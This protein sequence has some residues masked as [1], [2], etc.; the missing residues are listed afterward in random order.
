MEGSSRER[1]QREEEGG[2]AMTTM[3]MTDC[4][5]RGAKTRRACCNKPFLSLTSSTRRPFHNHTTE[6]TGASL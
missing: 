1:R 6:G 5:Q 4:R 2:A 3:S